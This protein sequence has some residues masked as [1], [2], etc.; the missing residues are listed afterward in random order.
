LEAAYYN[1]IDPVACD[2]LEELIRS[3]IIAD[4]E[5]DRRSIKEVQPIDICHFTQLHFFAGAGIWSQAARAAGW[6]D[7]RPIVTASCP[8]QPFSAAGKG[9]GVDD[10]RHLWPDLF[11]LL[12]ALRPDVV[13]G[14]QVSGS[15]GYGWLD[16]VRADLASENYASEAVDIPALAVDAPQQ[17]SRLYWIALADAERRARDGSTDSAERLGRDS[18]RNDNGEHDGAIACSADQHA[19]LALARTDSCGRDGRQGDALGRSEGRAASE[20]I[21]AGNSA[22]GHSDSAGLALGSLAEIVRGNVRD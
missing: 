3:G 19:T 13:V 10:P 15:A 16:G 8:C 5:V 7:D 17:R 11:R 9:K 12:R 4:G 2:V 6:S 22:L 20:R 1:E 18:R 21:D 14:E